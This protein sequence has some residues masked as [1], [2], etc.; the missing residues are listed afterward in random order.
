LSRRIVAAGGIEMPAWRVHNNISRYGVA[1][2][3]IKHDRLKAAVVGFVCLLQHF[4]HGE[5]WKPARSDPFSLHESF[6]SSALFFD[7]SAT[8]P[9]LGA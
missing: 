5:K 2:S 6:M 4:G 1:F 9:S 3:V 7:S 8:P